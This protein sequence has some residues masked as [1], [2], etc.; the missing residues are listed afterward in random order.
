MK[1]MV[2]GSGG[3]EHALCWKLARSEK[4]ESIIC[5]PGNG[6][7]EETLKCL[8]LDIQSPSEIV[9]AAADGQIDLVMVGPEA[10]LVAGLADELRAAGIPTVGPGKA[11]A[12]LEGSKAAAK[13]FMVR[14]GIRTAGYRRFDRKD[15]L[16]AEEYLRKADYPLVIKADGLAAG[17]GV[18]ICGT[19]REALSTLEKLFV[20]DVLK[21]SGRT[22]VVEQFLD[23]KEVSVLV[24]CD[25]NRALP[26]ISAMDHKR[27]GEGDTGP[28]TGGMGAVAPNPYFT[29]QLSADFEASIMKPT[30]EGLKRDGIDFRGIIFFGLILHEGKNYLLEYNVRFGDPE[31]QAVLP[32]LADDL[33][34]LLQE[35][36]EGRLRER[37]LR[38]HGGAACSVVLASGG[39]PGPY[40]TGKVITFPALMT[41]SDGKGEGAIFIAG[42]RRTGGILRTSGGRVMA[43]TGIGEDIHEARSKAYETADKI[44]F[45][46]KYY[47]RDIGIR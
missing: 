12:V 31:T 14:H 34:E 23:G 17:K 29:G 28:N 37:E 1:I 43:V 22:I 47:R 20:E 40:E 10:P 11:G 8:N 41:S 32:L 46:G 38:Y 39:Y 16:E 45:D 7:T 5:V 33:A 9:S 24:L 25:G 30:L 13:E 18:A 35:V 26:L 19:V 36:A 3:R 4:V 42:A 15:R 6:G 2:I 27:V 21:E 44:A